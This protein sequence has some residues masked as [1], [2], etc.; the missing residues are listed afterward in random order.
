[1]LFQRVDATSDEEFAAWFDVLKR[2][3]LLR[4]HGRHEGWLPQEWR[5]RAID[6][7]SRAY[8]QLF[9]FGDDPRRPVAVAALEVTLE[10]NLHWIRG[11][12]FVDPERRR[13]GYGSELLA[14]LEATARDL[15]RAALLF[16]VVE[17]ATERGRGPSRTFATRH[18]YDVV[19]E[20]VQRD[21]RWPRP[22]GELDRLEDEWRGSARDYEILSWRD[23]TPDALLEGRAHLMAI[24]PVE[25]PDAGF[26]LEEEHWDGARV[27]WHERRTDDMG[28]DLLVSVARATTSGELVGF[29]ELTVS[30]ERP[31]TAYQWDTLVT[32]AHRGHR[33]G[34]LMKIATMRLLEA[35]GYETHEIMTSNNERNV[36]MIAVNEALGARASGGVVTW[37]KRLA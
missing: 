7:S 28:R 22:P 33:L 2:A 25:V 29:S 13:R 4:D 24:M 3:E 10:D 36:A 6:A 14:H 35:G 32:R 21:L 19:E 23:G 27:R 26:G 1:M 16:W 20:N 8:H 37:R 11:D 18:G 31:G 12:L 30:R 9:R 17:D 34:G 15:G 5:A